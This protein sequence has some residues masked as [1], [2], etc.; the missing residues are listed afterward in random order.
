MLD[1]PRVA[2]SLIRAG[3]EDSADRL[4]GLNT[5][6]FVRHVAHIRILEPWA[7]SPMTTS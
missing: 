7:R 1:E 6:A 5:I 2:T 4:P 3:C